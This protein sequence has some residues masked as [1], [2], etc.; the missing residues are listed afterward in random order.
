MAFGVATVLR[1]IYLKIH[2]WAV[3]IALALDGHPMMRPVREV[4]SWGWELCVS[5]DQIAPGVRT[6]SPA[7]RAKMAVVDQE[8]SLLL[9]PRIQYVQTAASDGPPNS[10]V[11]PSSW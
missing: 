11:Q 9:P 5:L 3:T 2:L 4:A 8:A 1:N 6:I 10:L 7:E